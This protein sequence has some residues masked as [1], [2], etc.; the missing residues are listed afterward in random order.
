MMRQ[1]AEDPSIFYVYHTPFLRRFVLQDTLPPNELLFSSSSTKNLLAVRPFGVQVDESS[2][3]WILSNYVSP[4][5]YMTIHLLHRCV[6]L[7]WIC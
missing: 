2:H 7:Y 1:C 6:Y 4:H 5:R 3:E